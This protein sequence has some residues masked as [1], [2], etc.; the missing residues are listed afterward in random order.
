MGQR[1]L[2]DRMVE[3]GLGDSNKAPIGKGKAWG[4][5]LDPG[6]GGGREEKC[7]ISW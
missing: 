7:T 5:G 6:D 1:R 3:L 2:R 4:L